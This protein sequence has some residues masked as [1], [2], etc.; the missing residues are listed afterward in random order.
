[1]KKGKKGDPNIFEKSGS[2]RGV[3]EEEEESEYGSEEESEDEE[4][5]IRVLREQSLKNVKKG[6]LSKTKKLE[7]EEDRLS[8]SLYSQS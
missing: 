5:K 4:E 8:Q 3:D 2:N 7:K 1:M 6:Q